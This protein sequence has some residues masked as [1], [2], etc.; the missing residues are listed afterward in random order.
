VSRRGGELPATT[1]ACFSALCETRFS[2]MHEADIKGGRPSIASGK[3]M[4]DVLLQVLYS[5]RSERQFVAQIQ[6][7]LLF[8]CSA[9]PL[10]RCCVDLAVGDPCGTTPSPSSAMPRWRWSTG[11]GCCRASTPACTARSSR[12]GPVARWAAW[13]RSVD[14][15]GVYDVAAP[16]GDGETRAHRCLSSRCSAGLHSPSTNCP[17]ALS[18]CRRA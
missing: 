1:R 10:F 11:A 3:R 12:P 4:R 15:L 17:S 5:L 13:G 9:V 6:Y 18:A 16:K 14:N 8:G 2:G 7:N